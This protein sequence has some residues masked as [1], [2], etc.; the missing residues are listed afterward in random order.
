MSNWENADGWED[1]GG[2]ESPKTSLWEDVKISAAQVANTG[3]RYLSGLTLAVGDKLG[4]DGQQYFDDLQKRLAGRE[5]EANP[6]KKQ[7]FFAG[8]LAGTVATLPAQLLAFPMSPA[9]TGQTM[10][11]HG[12]PLGRARWG[13]V[14]DTV[15]NLVGTAVPGAAGLTRG[16]RVFSGAGINA[17]QDA[18]TKAAI[19]GIATKDSTK[20]ALGPSWESAAVGGALGGVLPSGQ[21]P[22]RKASGVSL[23]EIVADVKAAK[24]AEIEAARPE[25]HQMGLWGDELGPGQ[26]ASKSLTEALDS[27]PQG[28]QRNI[29]LKRLKGDMEPSQTLLDAKAQADQA[30][31]PREGPF[32]LPDNKQRGAIDLDAFRRKREKE[33]GVKI[34]VGE[35]VEDFTPQIPGLEVTELPSLPKPNLE[36][37][38]KE[39]GGIDFEN[40][41]NAFKN[42]AEQSPL[43]PVPKTPRND[44]VATPISPE[45]VQQRQNLRNKARAVGLSLYDRVTTPEEALAGASKDTDM[46]KMG[47]NNLRSGSEAVLR[48]NRNNTVVNFIRTARQEASNL[49]EEYSK[50]YVTGRTDGIVPAINKL[51]PNKAD[52]NQVAEILLAGDKNQMVFNDS[53]LNLMGLSAQQI[54]VYKKVRAALD[55]R[56]AL[57]AEQ[58]GINGYE[59]FKP[60]DGYIPSNFR[61]SYTHLVGF[62]D[63][64]RWVTKGIAQADTKFG[65]AKALEKYKE[66]GPQY[67]ESI[68][69][70]YKGFKDNK[71]VYKKHNGFADL[72]AKLA[73][74]DPDFAKAKAQADQHSMDE[75]RALYR[76][77]VHEIKK[78]GVKGSLGD[79]PWLSKDQNT[80]ELFKSIT[81]YLESGFRYD[82]YQKFLMDSE[83]LVN[84]PKVQ[85][86]M[87]NTVIWGRKFIDNVK[88]NNLNAVGAGVNSVLNGTFDAMGMGSAIPRRVMSEMQGISTSLM[89]GMGNIGFATLQL[90]QML[91]GGLPEA[92]RIKNETGLSNMDLSRA[93]MNSA[94]YSPIL[95]AGKKG[96]AP[97]HLQDAWSWMQQHGLTDFSEAELVHELGQSKAA[98]NIKAVANSTIIYSEKLTRPPVFMAFADMFHKAGYVGEQG[99]L[100]AQAATD[101]AMG[102]YGP[103]E[104]PAIYNAL[105][106]LGK[107][108]GALS[109]YKHNLIEQNTSALVDIKNNPE[110]ALAA[111]A[112]ALTFYG[113]SGLPGYQETDQVVKKLTKKNIRELLLNDPDK[114]NAIMDGML[115]WKSGVDIQ[116]KM[117]TASILPDVENNPLSVAPHIQNT[118]GITAAALDFALK[119]D[120]QSLREFMRKG[121]P[122][123]AR[124]VYEAKVMTK[125]G[126]V[127]DSKGVR[128]TEEPRTQEESN[129]RAALGLRPLRERLADETT[130]TRNQRYIKQQDKL[131]EAEG[132]FKAALANK[133]Q[134]DIQKWIARYEEL[135]GDV[136]SL[137]S[138]QS[139][140]N[141]MVNSQL[142]PRERLSGEPK[143]SLGSIRRYNTMQGQ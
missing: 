55:A 90:T 94:L 117:S 31:D 39:R 41:I 130:Y 24:A 14:I 108:M 1:P 85:S 129:L 45:M 88:G 18:A 47:A 30:L 43:T 51:L 83:K 124:N 113:M 58:A 143:D 54:D 141:T 28:V 136:E 8:K 122:T 69:L 77:D 138:G 142:S 25:P 53:Q 103:D 131:K 125:D 105:G 115:S 9:T 36:I 34:P 72:V 33:L 89:M 116:A 109:T 127:Y 135:G 6:D 11:E 137:V 118:V 59:A 13:A 119:Q 133:N 82:S 111:A 71:G 107:P 65:L 102:N 32:S 97:T 70:D 81:D 128:K 2:W 121:M 50:K 3:D 48:T 26:G 134:E 92:T 101:Y 21:K 61:G 49:F 15:G 74:L 76:F 75:V 87:P 46:S 120:E 98:R 73:E 42:K 114:A 44:S 68:K 60:R 22:K 57:A 4:I 16:M 84:D 104:R 123:S 38:N 95:A 106:E 112:V 5:Q 37:V 99:F 91:T 40:I 12:E 7:Q 64:G 80:S 66:M 67:S 52:A 56:Y 139:I 100:R 79:R 86:E 110:A 140:Q 35:V 126:H 17:A 132:Q 20:E 62:Y 93:F 63:K 23:E 96:V 19:A 27:I 10:L 29:A 78:A